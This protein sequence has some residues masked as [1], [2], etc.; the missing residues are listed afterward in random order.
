MVERPLM[1]LWVVGSIL[2][3]GPTELYLEWCNNG[4]G[5]CYPVCGIVLLIGKSSPSAVAHVR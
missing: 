2:Y 5:M 1:V 3:G 4:R